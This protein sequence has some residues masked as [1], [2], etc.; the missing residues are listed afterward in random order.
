MKIIVI[1]L[2]YLIQIVIRIHKEFLWS[3]HIY[4]QMEDFYYGEKS[5]FSRRMPYSYW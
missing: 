4:K 1:L 5:S 3:F 2:T